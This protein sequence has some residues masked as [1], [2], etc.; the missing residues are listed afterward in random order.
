[1]NKYYVGEI[2]S[3]SVSY[4]SLHKTAA[5]AEARLVKIANEWGIHV[6]RW[7]ELWDCPDVEI[8]SI[9]YLDLED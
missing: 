9:S 3:G 5:G 7:T 2:T 8:V 1:M 6:T 4:T